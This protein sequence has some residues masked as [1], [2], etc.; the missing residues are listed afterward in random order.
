MTAKPS[1]V[2]PSR[3]KP[4]GAKPGGAKPSGTKPTGAKSPAARAGAAKQN[5]S[6]R[7]MHTRVPATFPCVLI[8]PD[9]KQEEFDLVDLSESG[10]RMRCGRSLPAMTQI[11]VA[12]LLP[13]ARVGRPKDAPLS[14]R[15]VVVWS[16]KAKAGKKAAFDTGVFF[17]ELSTEQRGL[18]AAFVTTAAS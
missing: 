3:A 15:G 9:K 13:K 8:G 4:G 18:L 2:K 16:H 14:T 7:R 12:L 5:G 6:E 1:R 10:V 11:E 17:P